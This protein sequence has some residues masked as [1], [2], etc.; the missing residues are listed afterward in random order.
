MTIAGDIRAMLYVSA[1]TKDTDLA[2]KL[3]DVYP[4]GTAYNIQTGM[5]RLRYRNGFDK[6]QLLTPGQVYRVE[7]VG[8]ATANY[9]APRHRLRIE[10]AGSDFPNSDR[11]WNTGGDNELGTSGAV[12]SIT[13]HH[14][15]ERASHIEFTQYT[16]PI[17]ERAER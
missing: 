4:D 11:N 8:M 9:F 17:P 3:V 10:I 15:G 16:G 13:I 12:A 14:G 6:P 7:V 5:L 2:V 1:D